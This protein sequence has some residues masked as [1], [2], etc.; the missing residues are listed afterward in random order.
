MESGECGGECG[1]T[2][3]WGEG[4]RVGD[5]KRWT[6]GGDDDWNCSARRDSSM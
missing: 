2:G 6:G 4:L 3:E 1:D 5:E